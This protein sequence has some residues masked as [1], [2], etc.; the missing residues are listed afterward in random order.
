LERATPAEYPCEIYRLDFIEK[1]KL[2]FDTTILLII[3]I[4]PTATNF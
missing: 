4:L 1:Y 3:A 2:R